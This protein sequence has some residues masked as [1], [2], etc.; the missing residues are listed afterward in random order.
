[1]VLP[2]G[3]AVTG[4]SEET[5]ASNFIVDDGGSNFLRVFGMLLPKN[6]LSH[7]RRP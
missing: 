6:T 3:K 4:V 2:G 7:P 1:V 5:V